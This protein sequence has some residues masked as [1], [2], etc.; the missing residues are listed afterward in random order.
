MTVHELFNWN[1]SA[2]SQPARVVEAST[3]GELIAVVQGPETDYPSPV[4]V[5]GSRH[6][7]NECFT[8]TGTQ[9]TLRGDFCTRC[10]LNDDNT[11]TVGAGVTMLT[12]AGFLKERGRQL[13]VMPEIGNATAG[14]VACCGTK[15]SSVGQAPGQVSSAVVGVKMV[16]ADGAIEML[17]ERRSADE[18]QRMRAVRSSYGLFGILYEVTFRTE[19]LVVAQYTYEVIRLDVDA[20]PTLEEIRGGADAVLGFMQPYNKWIMVER[21]TVVPDGQVSLLDD[22]RRRTRSFIWEHAAAAL[23]EAEVAKRL[24]SVSEVIA[25]VTS[26]VQE[27]LAKFSTKVI[28]P[29]EVLPTL[30]DTEKQLF[31]TVFPHFLS[32]FDASRADC[33]IDFEDEGPYFDFTFWAFAVSQ[34]ATLV[35]EYLQFVHEYRTRTGFE[36]S[37]FTEVYLIAQDNKAL[38]SFSPS[39]DVFTLDMVDHRPND[40]LWREMNQ[41]YNRFAIQHGG[42][43]LLNQT[44]ELTRSGASIVQTAF[45]AEWQAI[46]DRAQPRFMNDFFAALR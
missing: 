26:R 19:P 14:A 36:A 29:F 31:E 45:G 40:P 6:S 21:R 34:W 5:A 39:E 4:R 7:L 18:G 16:R 13:P 11:L 8:T 35:P 3:V 37:L 12:M 2:V 15:D 43:P 33:M 24:D 17:D 42:R 1:H 20:L 32:G 30:N 46:L 41:E 22:I 25:G 27:V 28:A 10:E 9:V 38:L 23:A 44:K